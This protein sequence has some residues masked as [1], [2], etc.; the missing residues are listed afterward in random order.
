[1]TRDSSVGILKKL[2]DSEA[3]ALLVETAIKISLVALV[4]GGMILAIGHGINRTVCTYFE[5]I[6][7]YEETQYGEV[8]PGEWVCVGFDNGT[9]TLRD[10]FRDLNYCDYYQC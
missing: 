4:S 5:R 8:E 3:G 9:N 6:G 2:R 1:M 7:D 10:V